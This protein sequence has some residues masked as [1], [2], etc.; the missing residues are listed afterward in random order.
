[1]AVLLALLSAVVYGSADFLGG[2]ATRRATAFAVV[3]LSQ[4]AGLVVVLALLPWLGGRPHPADLL[5]G[6]GSGLAGSV[7]L[8]V[9][10]RALAGGVMSVIAPVTAVAA[11]AVP[12]LVGLASG[13]RLTPMSAGGIA[14]ALLAVV[15]V[16]AEEGLSSLGRVRPTAL[17]PALGA[18]AAFGL[19][20]VLLN[21]TRSTAGLSPLAAARSASVVLVVLIA[22]SAGRSLRVHRATLPTVIVAGAAD[23]AANA[24]FL[25]AVHAGGPLAIVGVLASLY[26]AST[27][28]LA[29]F[30]LR[31]RLARTQLVG[32][33]A[34][35]AAVTLIALPA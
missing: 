30:V 31:E 16:A 32:L 19:F 20:F 12:V 17:L 10:Y 15:L 4:A 23:M 11:A 21:Q 33:A 1:V 34:A 27:V 25:L 3:A 35:A 5:W 14:L 8:V 24:L 26:P 29:Q 13:E 9:F 28:L 6:A 2:L 18:G 7:G 22:T